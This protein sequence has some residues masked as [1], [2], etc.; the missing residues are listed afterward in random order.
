MQQ[1][2]VVSVFSAGFL[3]SSLPGGGLFKLPRFCFLAGGSSRVAA[4][5]A[6]AAGARFLRP[7]LRGALA[8]AT[9]EGTVAAA[10]AAAA[11]AWRPG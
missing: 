1:L 9:A 3:L 5:T 4:A 6:T 8:A 11:A 2:A 10:T 7:D